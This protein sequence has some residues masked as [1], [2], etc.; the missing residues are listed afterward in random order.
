MWPEAKEF[1]Q[2]SKAEQNEF[3]KDQTENMAKS[4]ER[5]S[6]KVAVPR[7]GP[8]FKRQV[9]DELRGNLKLLPAAILANYGTNKLF[10]ALDPDGKFTDLYT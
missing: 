6:D 10:E 1:L 8:S 2:K 7:E 3:I 9:Q 5:I 4:A